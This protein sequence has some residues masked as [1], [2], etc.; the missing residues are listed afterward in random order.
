MQGFPLIAVLALTGKAPPV[1]RHAVVISG[2][3]C[4]S[5]GN[6]KELYVH[7]DTIGPY[8]KVKPDRSFKCWKNEWND[9]GYKVILEKILIPIYPKVRLPFMHIY[10]F[11]QWVKTNIISSYGPDW[12]LRLTLTT[13]QVYKK[14][15]LEK[16]I[17]EKEK[18]LTKFLPRFMW[19]MRLYNKDHH[20]LDIVYD[21][22]SIYPKKYLISIQFF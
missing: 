11:Y 14:F 13:V 8:S 18:I 5:N 15:L 20:K 2:Y 17:E 10:T 6:L 3:R 1:L 12:D 4:D 9:R 16:S 7:D 22:T 19:I 21:G